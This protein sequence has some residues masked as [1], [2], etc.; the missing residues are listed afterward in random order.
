MAS[1]PIIS[2]DQ[3][4]IAQAVCNEYGI[5]ML[6]LLSAKFTKNRHVTGPKD[7][8]RITEAK[9]VCCYLWKKYLNMGGAQMAQILGYG[10]ETQGRRNVGTV[11]SVTEVSKEERERIERIISNLP[12]RIKGDSNIFSVLHRLTKEVRTK[13]DDKLAELVDVLDKNI[14]ISLR[15]SATWYIRTKQTEGKQI[16]TM[17][18]S[19]PFTF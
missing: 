14:R 6:R 13:K 3:Q 1:L 15:P 12:D 5:S 17:Q 18:I 4:V 7:E 10:S 19:L 16:V 9:Q 8:T 2:K 11:D